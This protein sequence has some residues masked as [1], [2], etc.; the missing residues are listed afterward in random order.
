MSRIVLPRETG[1]FMK[2]SGRRVLLS[3]EGNATADS[4]RDVREMLIVSR[5]KRGGE[6]GAFAVR[7]S[8]QRRRRFRHERRL[9]GR[10]ARSACAGARGNGRSAWVLWAD[11]GS[12]EP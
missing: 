10:G 1:A 12:P 3:E 8:D 2:T 5:K 6:Y 7:D 9:A 4:A 11:P